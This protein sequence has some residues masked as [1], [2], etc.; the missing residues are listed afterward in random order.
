[1]EDT[2]YN[3]ICSQLYILYLYISFLRGCPISMHA[4]L[5]I[6][7]CIYAACVVLTRAKTRVE[8]AQHKNRFRDGRVTVGH[9]GWLWAIERAG[10]ERTQLSAQCTVCAAY[11][12]V[13]R[14]RQPRCSRHACRRRPPLFSARRHCDT[15]QRRAGT[16]VF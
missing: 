10:A 16:K 15:T 9:R 2:L 4:V 7:I 5:S 3:Q 1:M 12:H 11:T 13:G 8:A 6:T 14:Q